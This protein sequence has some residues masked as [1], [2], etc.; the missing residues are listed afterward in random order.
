[1]K[2]AAKNLPRAVS[3]KE[4]DYPEWFRAVAGRLV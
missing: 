2:R 1:M 4:R 3:K